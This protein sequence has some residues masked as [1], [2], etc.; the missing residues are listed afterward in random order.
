[1]K[2]YLFDLPEE[3]IAKTPAQPR[4]SARLL[5]FDRATRTLTHSVFNQIDS[6][7]KPEAALVVNSTKV[8]KC[9]YLFDGG[10]TEIFVTKTCPN[11]LAEAMVRPGKKFVKDT[12]VDLASELSAKVVDILPDGQRL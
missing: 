5:V 9:R 12:V 7:L 4:D 3:L 1:M 2:P 6:F 10:Q 8:D 11:G